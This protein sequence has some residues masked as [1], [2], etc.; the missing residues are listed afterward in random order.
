MESETGVMA[1]SFTVIRKTMRFCLAVFLWS[2]ALFLLNAQSRI[3]GHLGNLQQVTTAE[4]ILLILLLIFSFVA[5]SGYGETIVNVLYIYFFPFVL[6]FYFFYW[7]I[8]LL[9]ILNLKLARSG[10]IRPDSLVIQLASPNT[11]VLTAP[12]SESKSEVA[13]KSLAALELVTRPFRKF[14]FLWCLL[15]LFATHK[16]IVW[17]SLTV[18][19]LHLIAKIYWVT[20]VFW[21]SKTFLARAATAIST[22]LNDTINKLTNVNFEVAP[23]TELKNLFNQIKALKVAFGF[24]TKSSFASRLAF[25]IGLALLACAHLYFALIF[26]C[27]YVGAAK[28]AGL[29]FAWPSSLTVSLFILA[30]VTELPKTEMLRI[31]GGIH[32]T[33]V[34]ALGAGTVVS[35]FRRQLEPLRSALTL[36][37]ARLYEEEMQAKFVILQTKVESTETTK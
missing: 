16:P 9:R 15:V 33:L 20:K 13:N 5:G 24:L 25:G 10:D 4:A 6:L 14:T 35:Y 8:R 26:S 30:Y 11:V 21:S 37:N 31:L 1:E 17:I 22:S 32:F 27:A 34:L 19:L 3:L 29:T 36:V 12:I 23:L 7:P 18:L 28:V 2:H